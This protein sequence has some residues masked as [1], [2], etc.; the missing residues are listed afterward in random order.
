[1][2]LE[3]VKEVLDEMKKVVV[4]QDRLLN[5]LLIGLF[6]GGHILL[7]GVPGLA[8]TLT[9]NVMAKVLQLDFRRIQFTPDLLPADLIGTMIY[10]PKIGDYEVKKGPIFSNII[11]ADEVN[12]S[13]AKVQSALLEAMQEK[14]VTIGDQTYLLDRP[15]VVLATQNPVEQE[16]TYPLPEAQIDRFMMKVYV[17]YLNK[18]EEL[19]VM[20]RMSNINFDYQIKPILNK[21][22]LF[23]IRENVNNVNIS[24]TLERYIIELVFAT[25]RPLDYGLRDEARYI[26][27]GVSP[28]ATIYLNRAAKALAYLEGRDYV[29]P[30]DIKELAPDIMNHRILLNYEAEADGVKTTTIIDSIL[31][32]V[33]IG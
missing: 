8:K 1:M 14:Q 25:R 29:L 6:T 32:K 23:A 22:D 16:G 20:R 19:E 33:A 4:G 15:F 24:E 9:I 7:E 28:R 11:L 3:K 27:F 17:D 10:K 30:E 21:E 13:P 5:R 2:Y 26:Q 18:T 31:R 12:R